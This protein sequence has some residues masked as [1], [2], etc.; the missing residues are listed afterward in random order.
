LIRR[1]LEALRVAL[2]LAD[3]VSAALLFL[4]LALI[5]Y[6]S[7]DWAK[8]W[9]GLGLDLWPLAII[10]GW[11]WVAL[12]ALQ[13]LYQLRFRWQFRRELF[14]IC[15]AAAILTGATLSFLYVT[16]SDA[17]SRLF[18]AILFV[19][20]PILTIL[21]RL[22]LRE[23]Y[24]RHRT[25]HRN[26]LHM[27]VVGA[28]PVAQGFAD[29]IEA[30]RSLGIAVIGHLRAPSDGDFEP[31]RPLLGA[32]GDVL[33]VLHHRVVD[34]VAVCL[35]P[36]EVDLSER[37]KHA[38]ADEGKVV[39][40]PHPP[41]DP[42]PAESRIEELDGMTV[43]TVYAARHR[44]LQ[45]FAKRLIDVVLAAAGLVVLSPVFA[46][47]ALAVWRVDGRP[48]FFR[49][50]RVGRHGRPFMIVKF[51]TMTADAEGRL[52]EVLHLN[53]RDGVAFKA[54]DDPRCTRLGRILRRTSLD[55]LPQ[56]W[57]VLLGQMSLVG[58]RPPLPREVD[59]Y[60]SWHRR[61]LSMKPGITGLWQIQARGEPVFD[62]WVDL[63]LRYIDQWSL[64]LDLAILVRTLPA[65]LKREGQ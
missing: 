58:P 26:R 28:N 31:T 10:Y 17:V 41:A 64:S 60:D 40:L 32:A 53:E 45:L 55:E 62:R 37:I 42:G 35:P 65:V 44:S 16:D 30:H 57:N 54:H 63:D 49:Q 51:R 2:V 11:V 4:A 52:G 5:R 21:S 18:L 22:A 56:L 47:V 46:L 48:V 27:L 13:G 50:L 3:G 25:R 23:L 8:V 39:R 9:L 7:E 20:Q 19:A 24:G 1:H 36:D 61:R 14:D 33:D 34:E 6:G 12:L 38:C 15:R 43:E 59:R 29:R